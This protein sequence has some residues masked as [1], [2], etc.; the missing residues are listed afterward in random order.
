[1]RADSSAWRDHSIPRWKR[2][3]RVAPHN[4]GVETVAAHGS[5]ECGRLRACAWEHDTSGRALLCLAGRADRYQK[6]K[7]VSRLQNMENRGK[8]PA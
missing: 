6:K 5:E 3:F 2:A 7:T 8:P 4:A 1:M